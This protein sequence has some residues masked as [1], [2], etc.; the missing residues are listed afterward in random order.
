[1]LDLNSWTLGEVIKFEE[2]AGMPITEVHNGL[3]AK[4]MAAA[5]YIEEHRKDIR[6]TFESICKKPMSEITAMLENDS[7]DETAK[8]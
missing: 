8:K 6:V 1:M 4:A 7:T 5:V 2:L 3:T